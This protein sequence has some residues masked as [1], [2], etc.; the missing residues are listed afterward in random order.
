MKKSSLTF[1]VAVL[2]SV[3]VAVLIGAVLAV[4]L[5][6]LQGDIQSLETSEN[7]QIARARSSQIDQL[8]ETHFR[9]LSVI[10]MEDVLTK[11]PPAAAEAAIQALNGRVSPDITTV[12]LGW[13]DGRATT[14]KGV[15]VDIG[16]RPYFQA[17]MKN[18]KDF[19]ISDALVSKSSGKPAIILA[20]AVKSPDDTTRALVGFEMQLDALS[21]ITDVIKLGSTGYGWVIDQHG[22]VIADPTPDTVMKL[23]VSNA[24]KQGFRGLSA[25]V[26]R[27]LAET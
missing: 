27:M 12:L 10:A 24:D 22:L 18:G 8:L 14:P 6:V 2:V 25:V 15:Y 13:P 17:I 16:Q 19:T 5:V 4:A 1:R 26:T 23:D 7:S 3:L 20:K 21:K 9:E 11:G